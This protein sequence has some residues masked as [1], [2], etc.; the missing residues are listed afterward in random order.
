MPSGPPAGQRM[1]HPPKAWAVA[2]PAVGQRQPASSCPLSAPLGP[3]SAHPCGGG[4][5]HTLAWSQSGANMRG[6]MAA[7]SGLITELTEAERTHLGAC[8]A[9]SP[10]DNLVPVA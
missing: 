3:Q 4:G 2:T 6:V 7:A 5:V 10:G 8:L 9:E 1:L